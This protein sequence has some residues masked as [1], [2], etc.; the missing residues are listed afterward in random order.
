MLELAGSVCLLLESEVLEGAGEGS[1]AEEE[2]GDFFGPRV[3]G[4][5]V[6]ALA[7]AMFMMARG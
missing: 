5:L 6:A 1:E 2:A 4:S 3:V 7:K